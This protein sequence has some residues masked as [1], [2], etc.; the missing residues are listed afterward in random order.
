[1]AQW[2]TAPVVLLGLDE[3]VDERHKAVGAMRVADN[4]VIDKKGRFSKR[5]GYDSISLRSATIEAINAAPDES[6]VGLATY[7]DELV[8]FGYDHLYAI[9]SHK[10]LV[11]GTRAIRER[12]PW[13]RGNIN[14]LDVTGGTSGAY[15][16]PVG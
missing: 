15:E 7:G 9:V 14:V 11:S 13:P 1:M 4:V 5:R 8:V 10:S 6:F 12:G 16:V 2:Q 3:K